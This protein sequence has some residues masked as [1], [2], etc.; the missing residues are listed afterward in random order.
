VLH[1][2]FCDKCALRATERRCHDENAV[3]TFSLADGTHA[4]RLARYTRPDLLV[5]DDFGLKKR[6]ETCIFAIAVT[7]ISLRCAP[8]GGSASSE[9]LS[10]PPR[11]TD[12][13]RS[14]D[15]A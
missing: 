12:G 7:S 15:V 9:A 1:R 5:L 10:P 13:F 3:H 8:A 4:Q 11:Y 14:Q 6:S 2:E